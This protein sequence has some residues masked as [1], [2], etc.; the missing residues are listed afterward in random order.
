MARRPYSKAIIGADPRTAAPTASLITLKKNFLSLAMFS[1]FAAKG[2]AKEVTSVDIA[3]V[4]IQAVAR[5]FE[6]N[7][8]QCDCV[9]Q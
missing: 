6:I 1:I 9:P 3:K 7:E 2:G 5:N 8:S 4:A